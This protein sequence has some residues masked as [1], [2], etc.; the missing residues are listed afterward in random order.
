[1]SWG[2]MRRAEPRAMEQ[3][4]LGAAPP[5]LWSADGWRRTLT[6]ES[7]AGASG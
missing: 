4:V 7:M 6:F 2:A 1:M 5:T 3:F